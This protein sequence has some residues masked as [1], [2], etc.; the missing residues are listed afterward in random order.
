MLPAFLSGTAIGPILMRLLLYSICF[1]PGYQHTN[2]FIY[3]AGHF[4]FFRLF[5]F[6]LGLMVTCLLYRRSPW[7]LPW[8]S[9]H[10]TQT[11]DDA[12]WPHVIPQKEI[13]VWVCAVL[14][15]SSFSALQCGETSPLT[16]HLLL[17]SR[18]YISSCRVFFFS[19]FC[20]I[21]VVTSD[22]CRTQRTF[23]PTTCWHIFCIV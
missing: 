17:P 14:M 23:V 8:V 20:S 16:L 4:C 22:Y 15:C 21:S 6:H 18:C 12:I 11:L 19:A 9:C 13:K 7:M 5:E 1:Y 3:C 2:I 10:Y